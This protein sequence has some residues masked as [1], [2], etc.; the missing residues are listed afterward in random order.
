MI[1]YKLAKER[2]LT[3]QSIDDLEDLHQQMDAL[4]SSWARD[5]VIADRMRYEKEDRRW[6]KRKV[7]EIEYQ[8]QDCWGF[9]RDKTLH[10]HWLRFQGL[11]PKRYARRLNRQVE[12]ATRLLG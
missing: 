11:R 4:A 10:R 6:L 1:N 3:T 8:M 12:L 2:G 5:R 7:E 9:D